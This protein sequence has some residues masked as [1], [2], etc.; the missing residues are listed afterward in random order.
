MNVMVPRVAGAPFFALHRA[1]M[2]ASSHFFL[3]VREAAPDAVAE[4]TCPSASTVIDTVTVVLWESVTS[5]SGHPK[6]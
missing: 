2:A 5:G 4:V 6:N 1:C 3:I